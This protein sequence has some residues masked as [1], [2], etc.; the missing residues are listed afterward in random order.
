[1]TIIGLTGSIGMGKTTAAQMLRSLGVPVHC[2][3]SAVHELLSPK[4]AAE[5]AVLA[6]FPSLKA[7][8][9]RKALGKI[10][11]ED[12]EKR[13]RLE[14]ILHPLVQQAQQAFIAKHRGLGVRIVA[15]DIPLLFETGA[16]TRV[17]IT[18]VVTAPAH[19]QAARVM[20][21][22]GMTEERFAAILSR[23]MPDAEKRERANYIIN[24]GL[25]RARMMRDVRGCLFDL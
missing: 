14:A 2:S 22:P 17:D 11:F 6:A 3:D 1:M 15:L 23:Q 24:S 10:V 5:Q 8:I 12:T 4:G 20:A 9:D 25:G 21:R 7:P 19:I 13:E 16:E 18:M